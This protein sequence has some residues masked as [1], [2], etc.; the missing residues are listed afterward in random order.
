MYSGISPRIYSDIY[1]VDC[2]KVIIRKK[3]S[4]GSQG[5]IIKSKNMLSL[6]DFNN[7]DYFVQEYI[8]GTEYTVDIL[9]DRYG[10]VKL[11]VP[12]KRLQIKNGVSTKVEISQ[13]IE[14]IDLCKF[15]YNKYCIPGLSNVQ[16]IKKGNS[17]YFLELNMRFAGMGIASILASYDYI[18]DYILYLM[19]NKDLGDFTN[20]MKK[21]KWGTL[22][23][24][25]YEETVL[26][27]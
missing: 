16:F 10:D 5:I 20:N 8:E 4:I 19:C 3:Q 23:C 17:I 1:S 14:I 15:I 18:S 11:V 13:D 21:I 27:Q 7:C 26:M 24:R 9:A 12:R 22:I 6:S 2:E 25:Y